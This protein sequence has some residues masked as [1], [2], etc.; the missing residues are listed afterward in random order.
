ME[1]FSPETDTKIDWSRVD[2]IA[3]GMLSTARGIAETPFVITSNYR[4]PEQ[5]VACGGSATDAHTEDPCTAFDIACSDDR[6]MFLIVKGLIAAGFN[7]IG[8]NWKNGHVHCDNSKTHDPNVIF[9]E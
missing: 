7:R 4:T 3:L 2:P 6:S 1:Y 5:S 9:I 8:L